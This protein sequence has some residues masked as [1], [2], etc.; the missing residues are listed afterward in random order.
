MISEPTRF[1]Q[2]TATP[3]VSSPGRL[4]R[5][6]LPRPH[7][8]GRRRRQAGARTP[9]SSSSNFTGGNDGL[10]TV[11]P[12]DDPEYAKLPADAAS[13]AE[14]SDQE[15]QR[16]IGL[17][18]SMTGLAELLQDKALCV[19]QGVGYPEPE[20]VA[21]PLDGHLAGG[22]TAEQLS[23]GWIGKALKQLPAR[24]RSTSSDKNEPSPL[25]LAGAPVRVPSITSLEDFQLKMAAGGRQPRQEATAKGAIMPKRRRPEARR[26]AKPPACSTSCSAPPPTPTPAA[27][28]C[29]RSARTTSRRRRIRNTPLADAAEA[30]RPA[31][32]RRPRR[33][34]LLRLHRR[35][36][37]ARQPG[38]LQAA[39][40]PV[41]AGLR[42]DDGVL[43]GPG[44]PRPQGPRA[45]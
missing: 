30:G 35:L 34:A 24:R 14:E 3:A 7:R 41:A 42:R 1:S 39:R 8:P 9:S 4:T 10:N 21:L 45:A 43:Q 33:P 2:I 5:A 37:H 16:S 28:G 6:R 44:S 27:S 13:I 15:D 17:H 32:R 20:P 22:S 36:R 25:A 26:P 19:V 23:E 12:F 38:Q 11:I 18:P 29:R 31:H 40:Q